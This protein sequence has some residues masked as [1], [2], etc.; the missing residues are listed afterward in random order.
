MSN[1]TCLLC[2]GKECRIERHN[3]NNPII[4]HC[5]QHKNIVVFMDSSILNPEDRI[6]EKRRCDVISKFLLEQKDE[7]A[8]EH[9]PKL[10]KFFYKRIFELKRDDSTTID[11]SK[12][13]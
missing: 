8:K 2:G 6:E 3:P 10:Y 1:E 12:L 4:I 13:I 5:I 7:I 11:V 9:K